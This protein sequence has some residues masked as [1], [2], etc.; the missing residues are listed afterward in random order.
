MVE[1]GRLNPTVI[2]GDNPGIKVYYLSAP[3]RIREVNRMQADGSLSNTYYL[4]EMSSLHCQSALPRLS[5]CSFWLLLLPT[6][7]KSRRLTVMNHRCHSFHSAHRPSSVLCESLQRQRGTRPDCWVKY[8]T[9]RV[10]SA[11]TTTGHMRGRW[12]ARKEKKTLT[13]TAET[14]DRSSN[15]GL[16]SNSFKDALWLELV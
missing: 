7:Q 13:T 14:T 16:I 8:Q 10:T 4:H 2:F 1:V 5:L 15:R 6:Q 3:I 9:E 12:E 11:P